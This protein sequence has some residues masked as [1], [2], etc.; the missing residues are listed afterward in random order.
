[1]KRSKSDFFSGKG[2]RAAVW[3]LNELK[4]EYCSE[5]KAIG[6]EKFSSEISDEKTATFQC[7]HGVCNKWKASQPVL[8]S[9]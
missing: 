5:K 8:K 2:K 3:K 7:P 6:W 1:M 4:I 9:V